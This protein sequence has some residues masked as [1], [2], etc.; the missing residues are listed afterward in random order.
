MVDAV[1]LVLL[2]LFETSVVML[3]LSVISIGVSG[4]GVVTG[5]PYSTVESVVSIPI[6]C[7]VSSSFLI[8]SAADWPQVLRSRDPWQ[9]LVYKS[10]IL[11]DA[12]YDNIYYATVINFRWHQVNL[13]IIRSEHMIIGSEQAPKSLSVSFCGIRPLYGTGATFSLETNSYLVNLKLTV[14]PDQSLHIII[15]AIPNS[16]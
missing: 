1:E 8:M 3:L 7:K 10:I 9:I 16:T 2:E 14:S 13:L 4:V 5:C 12:T 11:H 15:S 6:S